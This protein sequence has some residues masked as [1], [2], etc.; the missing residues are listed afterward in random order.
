M[1]TV[2]RRLPWIVVAS[3]IV[4]GIVVP[5]VHA[6]AVFRVPDGDP[7]VYGAPNRVAG[8][9][10]APLYNPSYAY[11]PYSNYYDPYGGF[12]NGAANV[13]GAQ[14]QLEKDLVQAD[15]MRQQREQAKV[16]TRRKAFD[17]YLYERERRPS[18]EDDR[19]KERL[20]AVRRARNDPPLTEI[21]SGK[22]LND[23]LVATQHM[24]A[25]GRPGPT[26]PIDE[27]V[28]QKINLTSGASG[29]ASLGVFRDGGQ[30][31]WPFALRTSRFKTERAK[32]DKLSMQAFQQVRGGEVDADTLTAMNETVDKLYADL[33]KNISKISSND[34]IKAKRYVGEIEKSLKALDDPNA[35][36][37]A[38]RKWAA[39]GETVQQVVMNMTR[40]GLR[41]APAIQGDEAAYVAMHRAMVAY[42]TMPAAG[43]A[44]DPAAK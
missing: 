38:T 12:L 11:G 8:F 17:E 3:I 27:D 25:Q 14:G 19:E 18:I 6:Q 21:W 31:T 9:Q 20:V 28:L 36:K 23:L 42:Y 39:K 35:S 13:I 32:M 33:K 1:S 29:N 40:D 26:V 24:Q 37:F 2:D 16:D 10:P 41:F 5:S 44:W 4:V 30:L 15:I 22:A 43:Q 34:Y 7:A